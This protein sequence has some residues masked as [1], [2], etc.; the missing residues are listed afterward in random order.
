MIRTVF[1]GD[2]VGMV[3]FPS[4]SSSAGVCRAARPGG[5]RTGCNNELRPTPVTSAP[6][7][8]PRHRTSRGVDVGRSRRHS[9]LNGTQERKDAV[10]RKQPQHLSAAC[11][12][13]KVKFE[14]TGPPI[15]TGA[16]YCTSCQEAGRRF[17]ELASAPPV[18]DPDGGT[19]VILYRKDRVRCV[20]GPGASRGAAAQARVPDATGPCHLLQFADV[21]RL[22]Q[23]AL[24]VDVPQPLSG[25]AAPRNAGHD[26]RAARRRRACRRR[27][28]LQRSLRQV[29]G[30]AHRRLDRD[31]SPQAPSS[32]GDRRCGGCDRRLACC[33]RGK[34]D[35]SPTMSSRRRD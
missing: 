16:C 9:L 7:A 8:P 25:G 11:R 5:S 15:L 21:P 28:E 34:H 6:C 24:A 29:H 19:G 1:A 30:E 33:A 13:G 20:S 2:E 4:L 12:C 23:R 17:E 3:E 26:K 31:G 27:A 14:G 22:H 10:N 35:P 32:P 18:L